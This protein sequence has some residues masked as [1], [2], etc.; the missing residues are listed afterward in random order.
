MAAA[1]AT[2]APPG[3]DGG[4]FRDWASDDSLLA[5]R[6]HYVSLPVTFVF[7]AYLSRKQW[8]FNDD[9]LVQTLIQ[10]RGARGVFEP[11]AEHWLAVPKLLAHLNFA[12]FGF[13]T[14]WP[15]MLAVL[16]TNT[17]VG[18]LLWRLMRQIG[19]SAWIA[20]GLAA[21]YLVT[22]GNATRYI[23]QVGWLGAIAL[24]LGAILCANTRDPG[25][26]REL[27][28]AGLMV[29]A[30]TFHSGVAIGMLLAV[31]VVALLRRG[32]RAALTVAVPPIAV[33]LVWLIVIG[34][35]E[36]QQ[37]LPTG[38][39]FGEVPRFVVTELPDA[40]A[41][42]TRVA[43]PLAA[44]VLVA[45]GGWL[46]VRWRGATSVR[47]PAYAMAFVVPPLYV[48]VALSRTSVA[49][50][51]SYLAW[52][53]ALPAI[54]MALHE[55]GE[56]PH[57]RATLAIGVTAVLGLVGSYHFLDVM[58][59]QAR[60]GRELRTLLLE[61]ARR[62]E[63]DGYVP[64]VIVRND[65]APL[66]R[67]RHVAEWQREGKFPSPGSLSPE[68]WRDLAPRMQVRY[69]HKPPPSF[70]RGARPVVEQVDGAE[71]A[72]AG[73]GCVR[74]EPTENGARLR[75]SVAKLAAL[76]VE[77]LRRVQVV[78][79]DAAFAGEDAQASVPV[80]KGR[81]EYIELAPGIRADLVLPTARPVTLCGVALRSDA[82]AR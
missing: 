33:Y 81:P 27:A 28:A 51:Y 67:A 30:V 45:V 1:P 48:A 8:F 9:F 38:L 2:E 10:G 23:V 42:P 66:L 70:E 56:R 72:A 77:G 76:S 11:F 43:T 54:G 12:V 57:R 26:R 65:Y 62:T 40:V 58:H 59:D 63:T 74:I 73:P 41:S 60:P 39:P 7:L 47:A 20:T 19:I 21:V 52:L 36:V 75:L 16:A 29:V 49:Y 17:V 80:R 53:L 61:A 34:N 64:E 35:E 3:V 15:T 78:L 14:Y 82:E 5:V 6:L 46:V 25:L 22:P 13:R 24:G 4:R 31:V 68:V 37:Q 55:L 79:P 18:H 32:I 71:I 50:R 69:V 44:L